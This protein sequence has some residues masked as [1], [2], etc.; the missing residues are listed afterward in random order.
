MSNGRILTTPEAEA[1]STQMGSIIT[2]GLEAEIDRLISQGDILADPN[3]WE[4]PHAGTYRGGWPT[5]RTQLR[6]AL[7]ELGNLRTAVERVRADI[8]AAGGG[9]A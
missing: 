2:G 7:T 1:A 4:G 8:V 9:G 3:V 6:E 5:T